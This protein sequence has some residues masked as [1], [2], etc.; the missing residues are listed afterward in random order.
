MKSL[1]QDQPQ[2][3]NAPLQ[4]AAEM[5]NELNAILTDAA[6]DLWKCQSDY[7]ASGIAECFASVVPLFAPGNQSFFLSTVPTL[8]ESQ[9][10]RNWRTL[11]DSAWVLSR[12]QQKLLEWQVR[13]AVR[14]IG[15][16]TGAV[17]D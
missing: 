4:M 6:Q 10:E 13:S 14:P 9:S 1:P 7:F 8:F 17:A 3:S 12:A 5:G 16:A 11:L 15:Q 2:T